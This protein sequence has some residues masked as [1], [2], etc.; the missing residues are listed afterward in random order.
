MR[1]WSYG[2]ERAIAPDHVQAFRQEAFGGG[3]LGWGA[4]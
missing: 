4:G 3:S 2:G 1:A